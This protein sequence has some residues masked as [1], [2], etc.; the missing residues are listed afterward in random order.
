MNLYFCIGVQRSKSHSS[1]LT[2][3]K[4]KV[5][6]ISMIKVP[7]YRTVEKISW[8]LLYV[9][10]NCDYY[11]RRNLA[12]KWNLICEQFVLD[13]VNLQLIHSSKLTLQ[14]I[15]FYFWGRLTAYCYF[16][17]NFKFF[18][19]TTYIDFY[20]FSFGGLLREAVIIAAERLK[21]E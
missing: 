17:C 3:G 9:Y 19:L 2:H 16:N 7:L 14:M 13:M 20:Y 11:N 18:L 10:K 8:K 12:C 15:S 5:N 1:V 21:V 4:P 6:F